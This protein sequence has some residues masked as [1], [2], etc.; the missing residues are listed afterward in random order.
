MH[1]IGRM[2][3]Y[4]VIFA[5]V[6]LQMTIAPYFAINGVKPDLVTMCVILSGLFYGPRAGLETGLL[7]G[8]LQD[9][10]ALDFFWV[11]TFIGAAVGMVSGN[12]SSQLSK[13]SKP[14]CVLIV[15][16]LTGISM[17]LHYLIA[18]AI[19]SYHAI[20]LFEYFS[21]TII[22]GSIATGLMAILTLL[23]CGDLLTIRSGADLL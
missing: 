1:K 5:A 23:F 11:N 16:A 6:V 13:E 15:A 12:V 9:L 20:D 2:R 18:S 22:P 8:L 17:M 14:A 7:G 21:G 10:F 4:P 3:I 19:S